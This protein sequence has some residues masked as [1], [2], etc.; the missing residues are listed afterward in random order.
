MIV[1]KKWL[2]HVGITNTG[3]ELITSSIP[4]FTG[5]HPVELHILPKQLAH[6]LGGLRESFDEP[7]IV[8]Y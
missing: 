3:A 4:N 5:G 7:M 1:D 6:G 8:S 2:L